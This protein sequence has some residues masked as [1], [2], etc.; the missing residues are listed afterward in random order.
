MKIVHAAVIASLLV[1]APVF[2][3]TTTPA[4]KPAKTAPAPKPATTT[5][6]H[7]TKG[8]VKS[9]DATTLVITKAG[10]KG[11]ETTFVLNPSTQKQGDISIGAS[12]DVRYHTDGKSKVASAISVQE[13]KSS[14]SK[15]KATK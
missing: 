3:Q 12:V 5:A 2:A 1:A 9:V 8:V 10:G 7:A 14:A 13:A 4:P 6:V 11:P 15:A